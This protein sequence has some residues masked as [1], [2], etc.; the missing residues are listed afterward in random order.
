MTT[1]ASTQ[2]TRDA[3]EAI[4][5][6]FDEFVTPANTRYGE[7]VLRRAGVRHGTRFLDVAAGSGALSIPAARAGAEVVAT[8]IAPAMIERLAA[9][10]RAE[11]LASIEGRVMDGQDLEFPDDAFDVSASQH[12]VSLFPDLAG[13]LAE[14]AR[15]TRPGGKVLV[16][17][18]GA[19]ARAEPF[20]LLVSAVRAAVP[21]AAALPA[22]P[23]PP[24]RLADPGLFERYLAAAGL[25]DVTVDTTTW[26]LPVRSATHLWNLI[27]SSHPIPAGLVADLTA[28]QRDDVLQVLEGILRERSGGEPGAILHTEINIGVGTK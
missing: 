16:V 13:G 14:M 22:D 1:Q 25:A 27:T 17:A 26:D 19:L 3:W 12:G 2:R 9:R 5:P 7:E 24:F 10:A 8:D 4:A 15:V 21:G 20:G 23:P 6:G 18:F 11:G 28:E